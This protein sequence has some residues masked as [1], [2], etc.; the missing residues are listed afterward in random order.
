MF[1]QV[2]FILQHLPI[3][4][5]VVVSPEIP[6]SDYGRSSDFGFN[7]Q[8]VP[9]QDVSQW[10]AAAGSSLRQRDCAGFAPGFP[11]GLFQSTVTLLCIENGQTPETHFFI[12]PPYASAAS[13]AWRTKT[14]RMA[15]FS[16][17]PSRMQRTA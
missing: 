4:R 12:A 17:S 10:Y 2:L 8:A 7:T 11:V 15:G 9:S 1:V 5:R 13:L 16:P 6:V 14:S 3:S